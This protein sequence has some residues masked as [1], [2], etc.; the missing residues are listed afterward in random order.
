MARTHG[1][2]A[3]LVEIPRRVP[4]LDFFIIALVIVMVVVDALLIRDPLHMVLGV[5]MIPAA[6]RVARGFR[7]VTVHDG[8][9]MR[10]VCGGLFGSRVYELGGHVV[11]DRCPALGTNGVLRV[12]VDGEHRCTLGHTATP[13]EL[14]ALQ[15]VLS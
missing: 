10:I 15:R 13:Q 6:I 5:M 9:P 14:T 1:M 8:T 2:N 7:S 12:R 3:P 11:V 4:R